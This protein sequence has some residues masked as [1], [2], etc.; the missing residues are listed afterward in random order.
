MLPEEIEIGLGLL[1][2]YR[3][4]RFGTLFEKEFSEYLLNK[5]QNFNE[6]VLE[7]MMIILNLKRPL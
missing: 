3:G 2:E 6:I 7:L 1:P 5:Y 4:K